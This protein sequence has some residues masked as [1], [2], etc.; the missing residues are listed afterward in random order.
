MN[1]NDLETLP[2]NKPASDFPRGINM[3]TLSIQ[4]GLVTWASGFDID[5]YFILEEGMLLDY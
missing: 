2:F 5:P 1:T 4:D 3:P